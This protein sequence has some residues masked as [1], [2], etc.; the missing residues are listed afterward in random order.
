MLDRISVVATPHVR[1]NGII[2]CLLRVAFLTLSIG[3]ERHAGFL[4]SFSKIYGGGTK[5][6]LFPVRTNTFPFN[7]LR[8]VCTAGTS[9]A[10][11]RHEFSS[12][13]L[14]CRAQ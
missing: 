1:V 3:K 7:I 8:R 13:L 4:A 6:L 2:R 11:I 9:A 10:A 14:F 12:L 5:N